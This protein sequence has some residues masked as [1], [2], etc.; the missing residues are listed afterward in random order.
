MVV[1]FV[2]L[3]KIEDVVKIGTFGGMGNGTVGDS[4]DLRVKRRADGNAWMDGRC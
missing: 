3:K 4:L 2:S 1:W